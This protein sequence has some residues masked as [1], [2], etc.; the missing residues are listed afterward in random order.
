MTFRLKAAIALALLLTACGADDAA[1]PI[2]YKTALAQGD[3]AGAEL[4]LKRELERGVPSSRLAPFLGEAA[5]MQGDLVEA[6]HWLAEAAFAP[7]VAA[8]GF[9]MLGRLRLRERD[10]PGAGQAFDRALQDA[11]DEPELWVDIARLR[12]LGGEQAQALQASRTAL[13]LGP[14]NPAALLLRAQ[15][16]RDSAGNAAALSLIERALKGAPEDPD[17]LAEYAATLGEVGRTREMLAAVR[18]FAEAA[19]QDRRALYLQAVL[20]ARAGRHDLARSLLQRSGDLDR[21]MPAAIVLLA[22]VDLENGNPASAAQALDRLLV[23]QPDNLRVQALLARALAAAGNDH[24]LIAR[25]AGRADSRYLAL[26]VGRAYEHLG[27]RSKAATHL[28]RAFARPAPPRLVRLAP[29]A[30][31]SVTALRDPADGPAAVALVRGL[32]AVGRANEARTRALS[33]LKRHPG[34][35]D[36][37]TLAGD[38]A[39]AANDP[40]AALAHYRSA[41]A[42]RQPWPLTKRMGAALERAGQADE[43]ERLVARHFRNEPANN[44][45]AVMLARRLDARGERHRAA[46]LLAHGRLHGG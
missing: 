14:G 21:A 32:I 28:D 6:R 22:L 34:S 26:L 17:L 7:D 9:H 29:A 10:L 25:F 13:A 18:R 1:A 38:A 8:H 23:R 45:A 12:Y 19:P 39:L 30:P 15:L 41:S 2:D 31:L 43:A 20:A 42:I 44:E 33:W 37:M 36:A 3:G 35:A 46:V 27:E 16:L 24:E 40:R 4:A 11:P 5:L